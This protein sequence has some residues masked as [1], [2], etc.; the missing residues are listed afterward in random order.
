MNLP[1]QVYLHLRFWT[2]AYFLYLPQTSLVLLAEG[3]RSNDLKAFSMS[4]FFDLEATIFMLLPLIFEVFKIFE[5]ASF[6][7]KIYS[8]S[9]QVTN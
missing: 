6:I 7:V 5:K 9:L 8:L 2:F 1:K 4:S 3:S